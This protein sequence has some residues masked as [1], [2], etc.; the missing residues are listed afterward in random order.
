MSRETLETLNSSTLIGFTEKRGKA[1]H[2]KERL[3]GG[4]LNHYPLAIPVED[5]RRRLFNWEPAIGFG[6][7][8][9]EIDGEMVRI[10]DES[11]KSIVN[12]TTRK[13]MGQFKDGYQA[14]SYSEWLINNVSK[15]LDADLSI[16]SAGLL[17]QGAW[18]FVQ[19][20]M[21]ETMEA[22]GI[23]FRPHLL[24]TTSFDG[25]LSTTY[26]AGNT[27]TVCDNTCTAALG[28]KGAA[29]YKV[30]HCKKSL[31]KIEDARAALDIVFSMGEDFAAEL[32]KLVNEKVSEDR[33][34]DFLKALTAPKPDAKPSTRAD[35]QQSEKRAVL[36]R[37][38]C[39]DDRVAP[40]RNTAW[41][42]VAAVNTYA[43][44]EQPT[45]TL[46]RVDR[47][48]E[49]MVRGD[50]DTFDAATLTLLATV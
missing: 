11:R 45:L 9:V 5:V 12:P 21:A 13:I 24:A 28:E 50:F 36:N 16:G 23:E 38:W 15:L 39:H 31:G 17:R 10:V 18:A 19:I 20:E 41:G 3:Q 7:T 4:E 34:D 22:F 42:V 6:E 49:R 44:H 25:S 29:K 27:V 47:N 26:V 30:K 2:Y 37:L 35:R 1:W 48:L 14:H 43:H 46:D 40:W 33:W 8:T 32:D